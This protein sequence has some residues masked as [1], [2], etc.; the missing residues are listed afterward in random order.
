MTDEPATQ[1]RDFILVDLGIATTPQ[2]EHLPVV[3]VPPVVVAEEVEVAPLD[4][5]AWDD[6]VPDDIKQ[7]LI[8]SWLRF[9]PHWARDIVAAAPPPVPD[10]TPV[11][12]PLYF[13][14]K[15]VIGVHDDGV[16]R[17]IRPKER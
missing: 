4:D 6:Y 3:Y 12:N 11:V 17:I 5:P 16:A 14:R 15:R 8:Y 10:D 7:R 2:V 1:V 13:P 9:G